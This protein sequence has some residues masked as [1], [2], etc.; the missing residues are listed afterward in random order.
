MERR[1]YRVRTLALLIALVPGA[2]TLARAQLAIT[3]PTEQLLL[4]P[5]GVSRAEDSVTSIRV[6]DAARDRLAQLARYKVVVVPKAKLCEALQASG[7]PCDGL[8]DDQQARQL[9]RFLRV[10]AY[11]SGAL[12]ESGAGARVR[13]VDIGSSGFATSFTVRNG[14]GGTP[15]ALAESIAVRLN[16]V[17]RAGESARECTSQRQRGQFARALQAAQKALAADPSAVSAHLCMIL[18]YEAQRLPPDSLVAVADRVLRIDSL[19]ASAWDTRRGVGQQKS[20][21]AMWIGALQQLVRIEPFNTQRI[22]GTATL[23]FQMKNYEGARAILDQGLAANPGDQA[24]IE[25]RTRVCIEGALWRCALDGLTAAAEHD[26]MLPH[27][28][29][30][31]RTL[32]GAAQQIP[33]TQALLRWT[34]VATANFSGVAAFWKARGQ[35]YEW[36]AQGDSALIMYI[37]AVALNPADIAGGLL[38]AKA[39]VD[40]AVWDTAAANRVKDDTAQ[41]SAM[42][43]AFA[44]RFDSARTYIDRALTAADTTFRTPATVI[45]LTAGTK[46]AQA[47]AFAHA[48]P[49]L[50]RTLTAVE[51]ETEGPRRSIRTNASFWFGFAS[52]QTMSPAYSAMAVSKDCGQ[53]KTFNDR[54]VRTREALMF[55]ATVSQNAVRQLLGAVSRFEEQM[56]K[57]KAAFKCTNF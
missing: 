42:R 13:V 52:V 53:A 41:L 40:R 5:L 3:Q 14:T 1:T 37:Q 34:R 48:Y 8:F 28:T 50:D 44:A 43:R 56:P 16:G 10:Q 20:D 9:A 22:L 51:R 55:G 36:V 26:T 15:Q 47:G 7:F 45:Q 39:M 32:I 12:A 11:T 21:T 2:T 6:M 57:V 25:L 27:D 17:V 35:A 18:V 24:M 30:W 31:I 46:L 19:N 38:I 29:T 49:W 23:L 33:D 4:L 54:L